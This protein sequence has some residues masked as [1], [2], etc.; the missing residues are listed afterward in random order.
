MNQYWCII[1]NWSPCFIQIYLGFFLMAFSCSRCSRPGQHITCSCHVSLGSS[2]LWQFL[3][4]SLF[5][6]TL[7]VW[8][9]T[10]QVC[11]RMFPNWD[12][13]D[14]FPRDET[15]VMGFGEENLSDKGPFSSYHIK[16][17]YYEQ[18]FSLLMLT[19]IPWLRVF[20]RSLPWTVP[21]FPPFHAV[22]FG[23]KHVLL[24]TAHT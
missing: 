16:G 6:M 20:V 21:L 24:C 13:S 1:V 10:G 7:T 17:T 11:C 8:R 14:D 19:L 22:L 3:R 15:G 4:L 18:D 12:L 9:R 23:R 2:W 5:L